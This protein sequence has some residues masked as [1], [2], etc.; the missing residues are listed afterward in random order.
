MPPSQWRFATGAT[1][2]GSRR[3]G[4]NAARTS[5][6]WGYDGNG[7]TN[8]RFQAPRL[9]SVA[10]ELY[11]QP[12]LFG[13]PPPGELTA[14]DLLA[15]TVHDVERGDKDSEKFDTPLLQRLSRF[16]RVFDGPFTGLELSGRNTGPCHLTPAVLQTARTLSACIPQPRRVRVVGVLDTVSES[17]QAFVLRMAQGEM[18]RG[19]L[20]DSSIN[21]LAK[22]FGRSV[23]VLGKAH[24]RPSGALLRIDADE[25]RLATDADNFFAKTPEPFVNAK[26]KFNELDKKRMAE[27]LKSIFGKWPGDE[28][29]EEC[30][31]ALRELS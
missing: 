16:S 22:L 24:Y 10:S 29:N 6:F 3:V 11:Q 8:L 18:I 23:L 14:F 21:E 17:R 12:S 25:F 5:A 9:N 30:E 4:W 28:T 31:A 19:V 27:G 26:R 2:A 1:C 15:E 20:L 7:T 13:G